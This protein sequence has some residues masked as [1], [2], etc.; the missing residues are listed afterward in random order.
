MN[1]TFLPMRKNSALNNSAPRWSAIF[2]AITALLFVAAINDARAQFTFASDNAG[3]Y[4]GNWTGDQGTGFGAWG[5]S[6][7][8]GNG[9]FIGNPTDA[10]IGTG[11]GLG[12]TAFG[13]YSFQQNGYRNAERGFDTGMQVGDTFSFV[14]GMNWDAGNG[15]KGFDLKSGG[16][17][18]FNV[19]NGGSSTISGTPGTI[20][21]NFGTTPMIVT[22]ERISTNQYRF[23]MTPRGSGSNFTNTFTSTASV[24]NFRL[25][26]GDQQDNPGDDRNIYF[27][28]FAITNTGVYFNTQTESRALTGGGAL[29]VS[30]NSTLTLTSDG[31]TFTGGTTIQAGSTLSVGGG[32]GNGNIAG[33]IANAGTLTFN[34]TGTLNS[35]NAISGNGAVTKSGSGQVNLAVSNSYN[36]ATTISVGSLEAQNA[37]ALGSTAAGTSVTSGA[38]LKLWNATGFT[39]AAEALTING[40]GV[41]SAGALLNEGGSNT[42]AGAITLG[43]ASRIN[44]TTNT[45][46]TLDVASGSAISG[47]HALTFGGNGNI[48]V[49]DN[50]AVGANLITK[51]G[52]GRVTISGTQTA[53]GGITVSS[54]T[55]VYNASNSGSGSVTV[56]SGGTLAGT[57]SLGATTINSGGTMNPGSSPGTQTYATLTWGGGGNYNWQILDANGAA[58]TGYDTFV[59]SGAFAITANSGSKFNIN[60]WSLSSTGP[61]VNGN[62]NN[63]NSATNYTWTLGTFGSISGFSTDAFTLNTGAANGTGGFANSFGGTFSINT[64]STQLLL[65]YSAP[66]SNYTVT[67]ASG[68]VDQG[69]GAGITG[70]TNQFTGVGASLTKLG[71]GT[72]IMTNT[73]NDYTGSTTIAEGTVS[74]NV[75]SPSGSAGALGNA[76]SAVAVGTSTNAV[77][78]GFDFGAAVDN[79]R[80]LNVIAG[81][82]GVG[83]R[84]ISTSFGSGTATQS[85]AVSI[86]TN[87]AITAASGS[88]LLVSGALTGTGGANINGAGAV[89]LSNNNSGYSGTVTL[90]SGSTLRAA[91]NGALGTGGLTLNG[92]TLTTDGANARTLANN[93]TIG[94]N[95]AF[96]DGSG[97]GD[98]T[99]NG[100][101]GLGGSV[102]TLTVSNNTTLGGAI[103]GTSGNGVTKAGNGTLT[104]SG[105]NTFDGAV[106][107]NAGRLNVG[108]SSAIGNNAAVTVASG[109]TFGLNALE[110]IGSL[111]GAGNVALGGLL[112]AGNN[113][114]STTY[115]GIM[116]GTDGFVKKGAGTTT[117]SGA[118]NYSGETFI[119]GGAALYSVAQGANFTNAINLGETNGTVSASLLLGATLNNTLTVRFGSSNNTLA[120]ASAGAG[121]V[122]Y[123]GN[124]NLFNNNFTIGQTA[125]GTGSVTFGAATNTFNLGSDGGAVT[126]V[127]TVNG[128]HTIGAQLTGGANNRIA[129]T[130]GGT[131]TLANS[132]SF[133]GGSQINNGTLLVGNDAAL[134]TG[135]LTFD[136]AGGTGSRTLA[137]SSTTGYTLNNDFNLFFNA[138][139]IGQTAGGTGSLV[140]GGAGKA[141]FLGADD[142]QQSRLVT[143]NGSHTIAANLTGGANNNFVKQGLGTLTL[144]GSNN[145]FAG[146]LFIDSGVV[147]LSGG[148]LS[149]GSVLHIG[150]GVNGGA[151]NGNDATLRISAASTYGRNLTIN[152]ETNTSGVSGNRILEFAQ[153]SGAATLSGTVALEK[154]LNANVTNADTTGV[155]SGNISGAGGL[156]KSGSGSLVL[157]GSNS[158]AGNVTVSSGT[159]A[160]TNGNAIGNDPLVTIDSGATLAVLGSETLGRF[161]GAGAVNIANGQTLTTSFTN[162]SITFSGQISGAGGLTKAGTGTVTL[163]GSNSFSG[164][165]RLDEG[166]LLVGNANALG[167]GTVQVQFEEA[168]TRTIAS[169]SGAGFTIA[170]NVNI[171]NSVTLGQ[172]SGGTGSLTF[173]GNVDLGNPTATNNRNVT[174][175]GN[176]TISGVISGSNS[177]TKLGSGTLTLSGAGANTTFTGGAIVS[178]GTLQL[179]KS[180]DVAAINGPITVAS[181]ATLLLSSSGNVADTANVTL[182]G[183]T[184][185][186]AAGVSEAFGNLNI[187]SASFIDFGSTAESRFL[188]FGQITGSS[189][190]I[191]N[192]IVGNQ[193]RFDA[194]SFAAGESIAN[195]FSFQT[196]DARQ[197]SFSSGT[198]TITAIPEPSTYVAAAGLLAL[199]LWPVRR[200]LIKDAKSILGLRAPA[201]ERFGA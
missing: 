144:S 45:T 101:V 75:A 85:G 36:G 162:N 150:G 173:S 176:H 110:E 18:I 34:R 198:F 73:A 196:S 188:D 129:I 138:L 107:I 58:G 128:S 49:N 17:T 177:L 3:N 160:L 148:A 62:A 102:R 157:S 59:S 135:A 1:P 195:S 8:G 31:N 53:S 182:S 159:V 60:L 178:A 183:G 30:N 192:M 191:L 130:G 132:N 193:F 76:S 119:V 125:G 5:F 122:T 21:T 50:V 161:T 100:T 87:T 153:A 136:F 82:G 172:T 164:L 185:R 167:A 2:A 201:R 66:V 97:T 19:N 24:D 121:A 111:T 96:G 39:S 189:L 175:N 141:F 124:V 88:T 94:G 51:D 116:S 168:G 154:T 139:T 126:R 155:L 10:G 113:G 108:G 149:G 199:F 78:T 74:I 103:G 131:L 99:L 26:I 114:T 6:G 163:S 170:N 52:N 140:L 47:S 32:G 92:G 109:A 12:T 4:G 112:I 14:W 174:V 143:V 61:D 95:V 71:A 67:V 77:A 147:N 171:F 179:N 65:V 86:S 186:R 16:T 41:G 13:M 25:Y 80:S 91:N 23:I 104:L 48:V 152:A 166:V 93:I 133:S 120:V 83:S 56:N 117:F 142:T 184:I 38:T 190:T 35:T 54:G 118:N 40:S 57:G 72:L 145:T 27:N 37:H 42:Y 64:N 22:L 181:T 165:M 15:N 28:N 156:T 79:A 81:S 123:G 55:L 194:T 98:L 89:I 29:V 158:F 200:R 105:V 84:T 33:S 187:T 137:S 9:T 127:V 70:G 115:S 7:S 63:F 180:T 134:G 169:S 46:L 43:S 44:A 69:A 151:T 197:Y 11:N 20:F 106:T 146:G 90:S 68:A